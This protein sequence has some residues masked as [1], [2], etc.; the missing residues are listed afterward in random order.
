V[1]PTRLAKLDL[2]LVL[3]LDALLAERSVT[4]AGRRV[5]LS[6]PAMSAALARLRR[7]FG[8]ELLA[9]VGNGYELT[10]LGTALRD[11]TAAACELLERVFASH[12]AFDASAEEREFTLMGSDYAV[13]VFGARLARTVSELAPGVR[14]TF[15][16]SPLNLTEDVGAL[17]G[18]IDGLLLPHGV[19]SGFPALEL[20]RDR[21]VV[22]VA[23]DN[24][25]VGEE[26]TLDTLARLPWVAYQRMHDAPAAWQL[27]MLGV[28][29]RVQVSCDSFHL[30][31]ALVA[32]TRRV[33]LIPY[34]LARRILPGT[35]GVRI[36]E[37]PYEAVP[38]RGAL[39]WHPVH[40]QDAGHAW[41][42]ETAALVGA[43]I[44]PSAD[45]S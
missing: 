38:L 36:M 4:R 37:T 2:N 7:H 30:L 27:S 32:G 45:S 12:A 19:I 26:L 41:L 8:D 13:A 6:Q 35:D 31:P 24:P 15:R 39:W 28:E 33:A 16:Q 21:W 23:E 42:R 22:L 3:A 11:R 34:L 9:R 29:P 25:E 20:Y 43:R 5:G 40:T 17:L 14:L 10:P 44:T 1:N 18:T